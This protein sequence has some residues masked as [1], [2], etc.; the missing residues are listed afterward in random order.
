MPTLSIKVTEENAGLLSFLLFIYDFN[1]F[2][3]LNDGLF[4]SV[5]LSIRALHVIYLIGIFYFYLIFLV[6]VF[7]VIGDWD[8][9]GN[10]GSCYLNSFLKYQLSYI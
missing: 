8:I 7:N 4:I 1:W 3:R 9:V 2:K 6:G 5:F 10:D